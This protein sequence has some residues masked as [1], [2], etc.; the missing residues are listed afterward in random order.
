MTGEDK[1]S[2]TCYCLDSKTTEQKAISSRIK[3]EFF[4]L[5]SLS[6][7]KWGKKSQRFLKGLLKNAAGTRENRTAKHL[8]ENMKIWSYTNTCKQLEH[9]V[10]KE[11]KKSLLNHP[12][13]SHLIL[14][15]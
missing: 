12:V 4:C 9:G 3:T 1:A 2:T 6:N 14:N 7:T 15:L 11:K 10:I 13:S 5:V 8:L